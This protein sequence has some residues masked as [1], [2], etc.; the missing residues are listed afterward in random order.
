MNLPASFLD[1]PIAHRALHDHTCAENSIGAIKAAVSAGYGIEMDIQPSKDG[2]PMV[3][4]DYDL[5][6]LT[7]VRGAIGTKTTAEL[8][9]IALSGGGGTIPTLAQVLNAVAGKVPLLI[10]IKDQDG[11]LGP[12]VGPLEQ[13]VC[14]A[15]E[16]YDGDVA[17]MSFN[18]HSV[19]A[20]QKHAPDLPRGL[21]T[22]PYPAQDWPVVPKATRKA[23]IPIPDFDRV[24][25]TFVSHQQDDLN[26]PHV[27]KLK[28]RGVSVLCWTVRSKEIEAE[29]RKVADNITFEGYLA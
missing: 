9:A 10:E 17:L 25:A 27:A 21:T 26:S 14:Q 24:G 29:A 4:H 18:P 12:D 16:N 2:V 15:L 3:F 22:C 19:A 20:C 1:R 11:G 23:L 13:A 5:E 28:A 7:G 8:G 6:R